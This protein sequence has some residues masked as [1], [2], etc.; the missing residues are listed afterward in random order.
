MTVSKFQ[1]K[2]VAVIGCSHS[3]IRTNDQVWIKQLA[4]RFTHLEVYNYAMP[5]HG[6]LYFDMVLKH[7][8]YEQEI[9]YDW[10]IIQL[11]SSSRWHI[12]VMGNPDKEEWITI[13]SSNNYKEIVNTNTRIGNLR[14]ITNFNDINWD[15]IVENG[16]I[17]IPDHKRQ[18]FIDNHVFGQRHDAT[19]MQRLF[20]MQIDDMAKKGVPISYFNFWYNSDWISKD[21]IGLKQSAHDYIRSFASSDEDFIENYLQ[22]DLHFNAH[23]NTLLVEKLLTL[24]LFTQYIY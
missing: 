14:P 10:I 13:R 23:S 20:E 2:K 17:R 6:T 1:T 19:T 8:M 12:P 15:G 21:N 24:P 4:D 22:E 7:I 18:R 5:G 3:S 9:N 11:Q 16:H